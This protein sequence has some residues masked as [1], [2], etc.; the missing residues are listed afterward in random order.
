MMAVPWLADP[1]Q[2]AHIRRELGIDAAPTP[3]RPAL[4]H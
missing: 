2:F 1:T 3:E 4:R